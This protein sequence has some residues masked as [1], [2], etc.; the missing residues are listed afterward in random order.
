[1]AAGGP[2]VPEA[3]LEQLAPGGR[4]VIPVGEGRNVQRLLRVIRTTDGRF[5]EEELGDV[6]F[7]PLIGAQG[8]IPE[9][10]EWNGRPHEP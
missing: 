8:W 1:V 2:K 4:L 5:H 9:A 10:S 3:L 6:R 7:V